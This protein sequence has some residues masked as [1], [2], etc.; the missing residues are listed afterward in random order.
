MFWS[1]WLDKPRLERANLDGSGRVAI[2]TDVGRVSGLTIDFDDQRLFWA[3]I[4]D[5]TIESSKLTGEDRRRV[6]ETGLSN[7]FGLTQYQDFIYWTDSKT[8]TIEKA[9]KKN[10]QNRSVVQ[11]RIEFIMDVSIFHSS[12]QSGQ[13]IDLVH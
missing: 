10:G 13:S 9:N 8:W 5:K 2:V 7:P 6:V 4:D 3:N 12:R 11:D 1:N